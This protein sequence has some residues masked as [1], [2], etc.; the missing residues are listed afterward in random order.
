MLYIGKDYQGKEVKG[1]GLRIDLSG[2]WIKEETDYGYTETLVD[3]ASVKE[4]EE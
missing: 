3:S 2:T 1:H 4:I